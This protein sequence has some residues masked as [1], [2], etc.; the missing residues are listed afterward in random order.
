MFN[1]KKALGG[2]LTS[3]WILRLFSV[4]CA[5]ACMTTFV[6][7]QTSHAAGEWVPEDFVIKDDGKTLVGFSA[8]GVTKVQNNKD[9]VI[10]NGVTLI[11]LPNGTDG[12]TGFKGMGITSVTFP[13]SLITIGQE[14]FQENKIKNITFPDNL[15]TIGSYAFNSNYLSAVTIPESV[16]TVSWGAFTGNH[17][18]NIHFNGKLVTNRNESGTYLEQLLGEPADHKADLD[19]AEAAT[20]VHNRNL[21]G[22]RAIF[23]EQ[24]WSPDA[25][26][27]FVGDERQLVTITDKTGVPDGLTWKF[28]V[29]YENGQ[30]TNK[31]KSDYINF[32][33]GAITAT[34]GNPPSYTYFTISARWNDVTL[35]NAK[36]YIRVVPEW[37]VTFDGAGG[38]PVP[39]PELAW[40]GYA[41]YE[42]EVKPVKAGYI[43]EG[44]YLGDS[45]EPF[46]FVWTAIDQDMTLVAHWK[47][48][49][50][51]PSVTPSPTPTK[52]STSTV[53]K[54]KPTKLPKSGV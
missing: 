53:K 46:D 28:T 44:W 10:P 47:K 40:D 29:T 7:V 45:E 19:A 36:T 52:S 50:S 42:P 21:S 22:Q 9:L 18:K 32:N 51:A 1:S 54:P 4:L 33:Q 11:Q 30:Y 41:I 25:E 43:F 35:Y 2:G 6:G 13:D 37:L 17:I 5:L 26:P 12:A 31:D 20:N 48:D 3:N 49:E 34:N 27:F 8:Q 15:K 23:H 16:T 38:Q 39:E 24:D 14:T